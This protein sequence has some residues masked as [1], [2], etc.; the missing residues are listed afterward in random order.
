MKKNNINSRIFL[1][2]FFILFTTEAFG[3]VTDDDS[4]M[5]DSPKDMLII[6]SN[7][8][9]VYANYNGETVVVSGREKLD[10]HLVKFGAAIVDNL[11]FVNN[12]KIDINIPRGSKTCSH[13]SEESTAILMANAQHCVPIRSETEL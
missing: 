4:E 12:L 11:T 8:E 1:F 2:I 9:A 3:K 6:E 7:G 13:N 10:K 5:G